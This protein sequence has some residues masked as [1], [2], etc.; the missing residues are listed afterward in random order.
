VS[1]NGVCGFRHELNKNQTVH[2]KATFLQEELQHLCTMRKW[3]NFND[4]TRSVNADV[5][6]KW[7]LNPRNW[8]SRYTPQRHLWGE[9]V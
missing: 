7:R 3:R 8:Q 9:D 4:A 1:T 6:V 5:V 2:R